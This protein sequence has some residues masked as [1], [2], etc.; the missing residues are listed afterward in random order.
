MKRELHTQ[1]LTCSRPI[2]WSKHPTLLYT[3]VELSWRVRSMQS[4]VRYKAWALDSVN[5]A[6][7]LDSRAWTGLWTALWSELLGLDC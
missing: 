3:L 7:T 6:M 2:D 5:E 4:L 1:L